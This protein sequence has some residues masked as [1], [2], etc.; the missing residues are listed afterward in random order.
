MLVVGALLVILGLVG[1]G[2]GIYA[3]VRG[4]RNQEGSLEPIPGRC[5]RGG[6]TWDAD[7][8]G[9]GYL[10]RRDSDIGFA[11]RSRRDPRLL[12]SLGRHRQRN[13]AQ[14]MRKATLLLRYHP[15]LVKGQGESWRKRAW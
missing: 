1:V 13:T 3:L 4:G 11:F 12:T 9:G 15:A 6:G 8:R 2:Y 10:P 7:R 14:H 5:P